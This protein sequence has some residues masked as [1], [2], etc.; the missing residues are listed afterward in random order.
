M[1]VGYH[2]E[3]AADINRLSAVYADVT[4][5][6]EQM[7][8]REIDPAIDLEKARPTAAGHLVK[9]RGE[10]APDIRRC[11]LTSVPFFE[12]YGLRDDWLVFGSVAPSRGDPLLWL[13]RFDPVW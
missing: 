13:T 12:L 5:G 9:I 4:T 8:H 2:P 6:L 3:F 11:N 10:F 1:K 7:F